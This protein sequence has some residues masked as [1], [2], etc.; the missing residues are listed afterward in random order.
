MY[1]RYTCTSR[2]LVTVGNPY[3]AYRTQRC[4]Y[5]EACAEA[6]TVFSNTLSFILLTSVS[7]ICIIILS[8]SIII[9]ELPEQLNVTTYVYKLL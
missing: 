6:T 4:V 1:W 9:M 2:D 7:V 5:M 8:V 3:A